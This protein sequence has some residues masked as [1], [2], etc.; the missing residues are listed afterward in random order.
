MQKKLFSGIAV[1]AAAMMVAVVA[2][3][4]M[5]GASAPSGKSNTG[6]LD[7]FQK[8][9]VTWQVV[10]DGAWGKM[11]Y[12]LSGSVFNAV[13]NGHKLVPGAS[14]T[15]MYYPDPW[16]GKGLICLGSGVANKGGNVNINAVTPMATDL[17]AA[18]DANTTGAK[19]WLVQSADV[20]CTAPVMIGWNPTQYLFEGDL[21]NFDYLP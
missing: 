16:P 4:A 3:T 18:Y 8:D 6:H 2:G 17:P 20:D 12:R 11:E 1:L 19:I 14:Y 5:A 13:F 10:A 9:P 7:L 21:I 15:L